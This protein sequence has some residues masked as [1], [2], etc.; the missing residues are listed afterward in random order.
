MR[1]P[2]SFVEETTRANFPKAPPLYLYGT[3]VHFDAFTIQSS[4][5][6]GFLGDPH[7]RTIAKLVGAKGVAAIV[8]E[9]TKHLDMI[10]LQDLEKKDEISHRTGS[11]VCFR[12]LQ[13]KHTMTAYI[14]VIQKGTPQGL[15]L[16]LFEYGT[17]GTFEYFAAHLR[18]LITYRDLKTE[19]LQAF[20][21]VGNVVLTVRM[22][23]DMMVRRM[24]AR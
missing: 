2:A 10:I 16:P 3:K 22:L 4:M 19:V 18:P 11:P 5:Y 20:R 17:A 7:F 24:R 6:T 21:E 14:N 13:I 8:A 9:V 1:G 12:P 23:E 15:K